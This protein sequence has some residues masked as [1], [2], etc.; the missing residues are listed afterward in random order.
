MKKIGFL[1]FG[2]G[3]RRRSRRL[4]RRR[5]RSSN[6]SNSPSPPRN[7]ARTAP[8]SGSITSPASSARR[9]LCSPRSARGRAG[10][11][12]APPSSTCATKIRCTWRRTRGRPTDRA[13]P[14]AIGNQSR[15]PRAGRRRM[16]PFR[17]S[18]ERR[19]ERRRH[20]A[21]P[22]RGFLDVLRGEGF[23]KPNPPPMFPNPP[24]LL[25]VEPH[26]EGLRDRIWWGAGS[27][28]TAVWAA[29]KG[30]NLRV[31]RSRATKAGCRSMF[32]RPSRSGCSVRPGR[33]QG[34]SASRACR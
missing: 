24:G 13:P 9:S 25:R 11:R 7:W 6:R 31:R 14:P 12:L 17:L 19:R 2:P 32:S 26:A 20:G 22:R 21:S 33:P 4:E 1:S 15:L 23:A 8:T 3:R 29:E 16:A 5:T 30:M 10:S 18:A 28:A 27:D 34:T